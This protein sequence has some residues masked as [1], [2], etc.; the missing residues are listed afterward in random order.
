[1]QGIVTKETGTLR[2]VAF[3]EEIVTLKAQVIV[4]A[5]IVPEKLNQYSD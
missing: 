5:M 2:S 3:I 1:M 4:F